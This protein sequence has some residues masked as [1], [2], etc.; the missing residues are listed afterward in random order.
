MTTITRD[1]LK[2]LSSVH[3]ALCISLYMPTH[4][5][6]DEVRQKKDAIVLKNHL[7]EIKN[8]LNERSM[9]VSDIE[10]ICKPIEDLINNSGYW[11][12]LSEGL[13][14]FRTP[15]LFKKFE[16]PVNF[17]P[18]LYVSQ[19]FYLSP[20]IQAL[21]AEET[22]FLLK[23]DLEDLRLYKSSD[24]QLTEI[25]VERI[26]PSTIEEVVGSDYEQKY[27]QFRTQT[28]GESQG[29]FHGHGE[30]KDEK[31]TEIKKYIRAIDKGLMELLPN[32]S[33]PL[34][35]AGVDHIFSYFKEI[36]SYKNIYPKHISG[37]ISSIDLNTLQNRASDILKPYFNK[38]R[39]EKAEMYRQFQGTLRTANSIDKVIP[40]VFDGKVDTLFV[41][42]GHDVFGIYNKPEN[43]VEI[44]KDGEL[45]EVSLYNLAAMQS[46]L[47][48]ADVYFVDEDEMPD[49]FSTIN[50]LF[51]Y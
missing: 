39:S 22:F 11:N 50:A 21:N 34:V 26:I 7:K 44:S 49:G 20:L 18:R 6:G 48:G 23:L 15:N 30:G 32:E 24:H 35:V 16:L 13:A 42:R 1:N 8:I 47:H 31:K 38:T 33:A 43:K 5:A 2:E 9:S 45:A 25:D 12:K 27:L 14:I 46:F 10:A 3:D 17:I 19:D 4:I 40:A 36:S 41:K 51:R 29:L 28:G 37:N